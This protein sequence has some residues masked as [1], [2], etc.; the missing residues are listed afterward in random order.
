[1]SLAFTIVELVSILSMGWLQSLGMTSSV[2]RIFPRVGGG[3][4]KFGKCAFF[5]RVAL[6]LQ[7]QEKTP[8]FLQLPD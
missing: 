4:A 1:M 3:Q 6:N 5:H 2:A 7:V 8:P